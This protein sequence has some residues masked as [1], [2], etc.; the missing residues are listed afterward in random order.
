M[1]GMLCGND[2]CRKPRNRYNPAFTLI[3]IMVA[4]VLTSIVVLVAYTMAQV[5][6]DTRARLATHLR[7]VESARAGRELL[8]DALRNARTSQR[9]GDP[10]FSVTGDSLSFVAAGGAA[11]L[12]PDYDWWITARPGPGGLR[13]VAVPLGHAPLAAVAMR[14]PDITRW[15]IRTLAADG[16]Q[17]LP[18]WS[19]PKIMPRAITIAFWHGTDPVGTPLRVVLW[20]G[21]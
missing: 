19:Q 9:A 15:D 16:P 21:L 12:D 1:A 18:E 2:G 8:R 14:V 3:E 11:P 5:S 13:I 6:F 4:I 10:G 20:P 17:W 7:A